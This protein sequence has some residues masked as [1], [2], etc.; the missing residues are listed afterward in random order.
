[1]VWSHPTG[2][3]QA[4]LWPTSSHRLTHVG[5]IGAR[6]GSMHLEDGLRSVCTFHGRMRHLPNYPLF[7]T[8]KRRLPRPHLQQHYKEESKKQERHSKA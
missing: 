4:H 8:Y 6:P 2:A 1:M 7:S 5:H 3:S